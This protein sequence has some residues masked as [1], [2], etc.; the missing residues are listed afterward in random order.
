LETYLLT[1]YKTT[2]Y[3]DEGPKA[4]GVGVR[5]SIWDHLIEFMNSSISVEFHSFAL[6]I[7][8]S[9]IVPFFPLNVVNICFN[10]WPVSSVPS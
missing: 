7:I 5:L 3:W 1:T 9:I 2:P 6:P 10:G 4:G 8:I